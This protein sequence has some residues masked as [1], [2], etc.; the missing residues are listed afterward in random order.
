MNI[1]KKI[2]AG[3]I[4]A[5]CLAMSV[6]ALAGTQ[7]TVD[8]RIGQLEFDGGYPTPTTMDHLMNEMDFM[9]ATQAYMWGIPAVGLIE[10]KNAHNNVFHAPDG[11]MVSY[12]TQ[13]QKQGILTPNFTTPY[14]AS[15]ADL[16]KTGPV[17]LTL[18]KGLMAGM[19]L[20]IHQR[21]LADLGV[22]GPD[23][24]KGGKYLILPPGYDK[25][26]P[27]EGYFVVKATSNN[28]LFG[29]R[30]LDKD[31]A[32]AIKR[33][34]PQITS[35]LYDEDKT[36]TT[37]HVKAASEDAWSQTPPEGMA[38]WKAINQIVQSEVVDERDRF[39]LEHLRFLGIEKGK[40]FTP[41]E[42]QT[43]ILEE[44]AVV[45]QAM[46]KANNYGKRFEPAFWPGTH[47]KHAITVSPSQRTNNWDQF[48]ER[49]SWFYE[50][51]TISKAMLS[52]TPGVGQRYIV[53]YQDKDGNWLNGEH[54]Y[55]LHVPANV[56]A[57]QF[58]STTVYDEKE[59]ELIINDEKS[60]DIGSTKQGLKTNADGSVDI[61]YGP[62]PVKG[63]EQNWIQTKP[64]DGWFTYFRF[65]APTEAFF[66]KSWTLGDIE[67]VDK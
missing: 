60:P 54:T 37:W 65:Y 38:Y 8:T 25:P 44:G 19:I 53:T 27:K 14:I 16:S 58:W 3:V 22:V 29:V 61:Y 34:V 47:W 11:Q 20:D 17:V 39:M 63:F 67:R 26:I 5:S 15:F 50:A 56:P 43:K 35:S 9:R 42:A 18:P 1:R 4:S 41:T 36:G 30:L 57:K 10:W 51:V 64:G 13:K 6:Q 55:K 48:D 21:V 45:G 24:G 62:K 40:L 2:L 66:D 59:R 7:E 32:E 12:L 23:A 33:L 28:V 31:K 52:Q 49:A 46:A